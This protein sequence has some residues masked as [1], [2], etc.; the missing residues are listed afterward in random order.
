[1]NPNTRKLRDL[2]QRLWL[3]NITR[4]LLTSGT[5]ARYIRELSVTGLT[6]NPTIFEHAIGSG[7][8]YD[9]AIRKLATAGLSGEDLFFDYPVARSH[10][11]WCRSASAV[12][13]DADDDRR[14]EHDPPDAGQVDRLVAFAEPVH[15]PQTGGEQIRPP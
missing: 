12:D 14:V 11:C 2:G 5:M 4:E 13:D 6:S 10:T 3:D 8:D 7:T 1:M 15:E 9:D